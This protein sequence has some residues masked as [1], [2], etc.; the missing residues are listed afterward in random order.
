VHDDRSAVFMLTENVA[1][2]DLSHPIHSDNCIIQPDNTC[3]REPPAYTS[4]DYRFATPLQTYILQI[5]IYDI[6]THKILDCNMS[7]SVYLYSLYTFISFHYSLFIFRLFC[8][9]LIISCLQSLMLSAGWK[10]DILAIKNLLQRPLV[11]KGQPNN[12]G[13]PGKWPLKTV[14]VFI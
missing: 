7:L 4:R 9:C 1:R 3:L 12:Q 2:T 14:Y 5:N 8:C 10:E 6:E 11:S 13:S